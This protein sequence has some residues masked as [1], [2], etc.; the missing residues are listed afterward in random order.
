MP[1]KIDGEYNN[2]LYED[3]RIA[4]EK[5]G[6]Q[7]PS[8]DEE[9][10]NSLSKDK[11]FREYQLEAIEYTN[12]YIENMLKDKQ[13]HLLY[14][15]ATGSG[16][17]LVMAYLILYFFK[18]GY[19]TFLFFVNNS[20]IIEKTKDNFLEKDSIKYLF[21]K[22]IVLNDKKVEINEITSFNDINKDNINI[23]FTTVQALHEKL[24][25]QKENQISLQDFEDNKIILLADEAHHLNA[26]IKKGKKTKEDIETIESWE[27]AINSILYSNKNSAL[28][29]FTATPDFRNENILKKYINKVIYN[30]DLIQF[31]KDGYTKDFDNY[32]S[33]NDEI[34]RLVLALLMSQYRRKLFAK[35]K[36]NVKPVVLAKCK[37]KTEKE[38]FINNYI[39]FLNNKFNEEDIKD[40]ERTAEGY[41]KKMFEF[42][43]SNNITYKNLVDEIKL[44]F[45]EAHIIELDSSMSLEEKNYKNKLVND[46]ESLSNPYRLIFVVDMLNEGWDVLNLYDI[47]R[48]Y[49]ERDARGNKIGK[50]T[51]QEA[52]LIGR[53]VRYYPFYF[54]TNQETIFNKRKYDDDINN[55][56]RICETLLFHSKTDSKYLYELKEALK[57]QG[58]DIDDK[59]KFEYKIKDIYKNSKYFSELRLFV[60]DRK[61]VKNISEKVPDSFKFLHTQNFVKEDIIASLVDDRKIDENKTKSYTKDFLIRDFSKE[62]YSII[63]KA[64]RSCFLPFNILKKYLPYLKNEREFFEDEKYIGGFQIAIISEN[65]NPLIQEYYTTLCDFFIKLR[66]KFVGWKETYIGTEDFKEVLLKDYIK[67]T[68]REKINPDEYGEGISQNSDRMIEKYKMDLSQYDWYVYNDNYGTTE[69]KS[70]VKYFS[71]IV[72]EIKKHYSEVYLIR[73]ERNLHIYSFDEGARF[74]PDYIL[75]LKKDKESKGYIQKQIFIEPKG[76]HLLDKDM[77]KEKF[78]KQLEEKAIIRIIKSDCNNNYNVYGLPFYNE[79]MGTKE[80]KESIEKYVLEDEIKQEIIINDTYDISELND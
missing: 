54:N 27:T 71:T 29:E 1:I 15:M 21:N 74:E 55:D 61:I 68:L 48:L 66:K 19:N 43:K 31:R 23:M 20:N 58:M 22:E 60:N 28:I 80:I 47:V 35:Y 25:I 12:Y 72:D 45:G 76:T 63:N 78:L 34:H 11:A 10:L 13:L 46:L 69:E 3:I 18:K 49:V 36:L 14:Y 53:G 24:K 37:T 77:W 41:A 33:N 67:D 26:E 2:F 70:F 62:H 75:L 6:V 79:E 73:N 9:I 30:Y 38:Q 65:E 57:Q 52:Q 40:I 59:V 51:T 7:L 44:D 39:D 50:S 16:K 42:Y 17:T 64:Y 56:L 8:A 4:K 5:L 32:Q